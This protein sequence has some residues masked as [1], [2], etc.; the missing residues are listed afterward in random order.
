MDSDDEWLQAGVLLFVNEKHFMPTGLVH[1][2]TDC[3]KRPMTSKDSSVKKNPVLLPI[4][5]P[6]GTG[7]LSS[8]V[9]R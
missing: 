9:G 8:I 3:G 1:A 6:I 2:P 5:N 7:M 4:H